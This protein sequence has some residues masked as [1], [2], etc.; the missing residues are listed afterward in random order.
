MGFIG[1]LGGSVILIRHN[2]TIIPPAEQNVE[3]N[4]LVS[5]VMPESGILG[6]TKPRNKLT[7]NKVTGK[8][9]K[10]KKFQN[11]LKIGNIVWNSKN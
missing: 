8:I 6:G 2:L 3:Y 1:G 11:L 4:T 9:P 10:G 5:R 7:R